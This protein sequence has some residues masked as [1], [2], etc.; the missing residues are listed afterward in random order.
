M[1]HAADD[2]GG[3]SGS[4]ITVAEALT[5][6]CLEDASVLA[7]ADGLE[8]RVR[9]VNV[10]EDAN[11]V[12]WMR[13]GELL[14]TTGYSI[15]DDEGALRELVPALAER[16]L[17]G[18]GIKLGLYIEELPED[19]RL[20]ADRLAFPIIGLPSRVMFNDILSEVLGS[21]L[22]RQAVE[23]ERSN[24]IHTRLTA[25]ALD[26]GSFHDLAEAVAELVHRPVAIRDAQG[27]ELAATAGRP[28]RRRRAARDPRD[29]G[30]RRRTAARSR[31]GPA[32]RRSF[33]TSTRRWST[34]PRSLRWPS[35]R[36][37]RWSRASS[38]T[39]RCC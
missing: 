12:R 30:R 26:G 31:S 22:N 4:T 29:Q 15:R 17:A 10:L 3:P 9:G 20:E 8:R 21:I 13:G 28:A 38:A 36:S 16:G 18:L 33:P 19:V 2:G 14:L 35:P 5:M 37:G 23:L 25:V 6:P 34:R 11:I 39:A 24:A 1:A 32:A 27:G 7:G